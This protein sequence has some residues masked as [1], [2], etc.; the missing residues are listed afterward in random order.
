VRRRLLAQIVAVLAVAVSVR[1]SAQTASTQLLGSFTQ[2]VATARPDVPATLTIANRD[3]VILRASVLNRSSRDRVDSA[4]LLLDQIAAEGGP[5]R[6]SPQ[7]LEGAV[8][9]LVNNHVAFAITP[10]DVDEL[11]GETLTDKATTTVARLQQALN[12]KVE[13][14][15]PRLM[16]EGALFALGATA[17]FIL[18]LWALQIVDRTARRW[19][20]ASTE[21]RL[22]ASR[23][24]A[25]AILRQARIV[26]YEQRL[27]DFLLLAIGLVFAYWWLSFVLRRFPY[28]RPWGDA[29][30]AVLVDRLAWLGLGI[31]RA[32]PG[33][34]TVVIII[35]ATR[36]L[37][38]LSTA[39]FDA[40]ERGRITLPWIYPDTAA[41]TRKLTTALLWVF[42]L[43]VAY[44]FL[45]G[46]G[47]DA[48]KGVTVF[49]GVIVS[50]GSTGI[51]NQLMSG[52]TV[53]YSRA[54]RVGDYVRVGDIEG[55]VKHLGTLAVK[56]ETPFREDVTIPNTVII[57]REVTNY[58]R[59]AS[60]TDV[61][62]TTSLS[63]GYDTPWRQVHAMLLQ[64]ADRT[65]NVKKTTTPLV[66]QTALEDF[67]VKYQLIVTLDD[68]R[69]RV[70]TLGALHGHIQDVF[71]EFGV[72]IMSPHY[73]ADPE[74]PKVVAKAK[75]APPPAE[76]PAP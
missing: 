17:L 18:L 10:A 50:L 32:I 51:V 14:R 70:I 38:R 45:P 72:Q 42:A 39:L 46:S 36:V 3:I 71:N 53:T 23:K 4:R 63:I 15:S 60:A 31:L 58:T 35:L 25:A 48:F 66:F 54:L 21:R 49:L 56:V 1:V 69:L 28:S 41:P 33:F 52:L 13:A 27:I 9:I 2:L 43:I 74:S 37:V 67:Y 64:A 16:L 76:R 29:L 61:F 7:L 8:F 11:A 26:H 47:T 57:S 20:A 12:E 73:L 62:A 5:I 19:L 22:N 65:P 40:V 6:V 34:I 30:R 59:N 24:G 55:T 75:W 44:P 68:P